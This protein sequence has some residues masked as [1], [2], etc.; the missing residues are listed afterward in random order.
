MTKEE[1]HRLT[2]S[3]QQV[4][5]IRDVEFTAGRAA[6]LRAYE[7]KNGPLFLR[8]LKDRNL[9]IEE[10]S[11]EGIGFNFLAK[12]GLLAPGA[13]DVSSG[14]AAQRSI[15]GGFLFTAGLDNICAP[16]RSG[17]REYLM[18][19][20]IRSAPADLLGA[21]ACWK[22]GTYRLSVRGESR[23]AE[24]FGENLVLRRR[25]ETVYGTRTFIL[26]DEIENQALR[27]EP[28]LILY[29]I[30]FGYP[31]LD[32]GTELLLPSLRTEP[33]D[34]AAKAH[35]GT[36]YVMPAP[37]DNAP[38]SVFLH[39]LASRPDGTTMACV[40][41]E[42]L[43]LGLRLEFSIRDLPYFMQWQSTASGDYALGLEPANASVFGRAYHEERGE[44]AVLEPLETQTKELRFTILDGSAEIDAARREVAALAAQS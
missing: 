13:P 8:V 7:I 18:H 34:E 12:T 5:G 28:F 25:I 6:G 20:R 21:E 43:G 32:A 38:E 16:C 3:L 22:D 2:G 31:L 10:L 9:D 26:R 4:A 41:N 36:W 30:N 1:L 24:L 11:Y 39:T 35:L 42:T 23:E 37:A 14:S 15:M 33:R 40:V 44:L 27:P 29:H 17:D 19:G